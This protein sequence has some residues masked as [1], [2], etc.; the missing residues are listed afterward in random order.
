MARRANNAFSAVWFLI[1]VRWRKNMS[2][3]IIKIIRIFEHR[4]K[5]FSIE[6][7]IDK[8]FIETMNYLAQENRAK[9]TITHDDTDDCY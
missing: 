8:Q 5:I 2:N 7:K 3:Q 1:G 6:N 9:T 4:F